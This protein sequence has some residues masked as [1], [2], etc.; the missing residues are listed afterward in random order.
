MRRLD[1]QQGRARSP[2]LGFVGVGVV[3]AGAALWVNRPP[4]AHDAS[5]LHAVNAASSAQPA[6][7]SSKD[8]VAGTS[9]AGALPASLD[10][11]SPPHLPTDGRGH[12]ARSRAVRD[13]F[14]YF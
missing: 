11:S 6:L 10:G 3:S 14:D 9:T 7:A 2:W 1:R 12:L 13:F 8:M 4:S 5:A